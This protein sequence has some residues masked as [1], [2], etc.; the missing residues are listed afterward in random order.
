M[1]TENIFNKNG[2]ELKTITS[3]AGTE[4]GIDRERFIKLAGE[5]DY[6]Y[7]VAWLDNIVLIGTCH[8]GN[9]HFYDPD[10]HFKVME[11]DTGLKY[12]QK[13]RVFNDKKELFVWRR[14]N[15]WD[16]RI[17]EDDTGN[18]NFDVVVAQQLLFGTKDTTTPAQKNKG[19]SQISED[20]GTMLVLPFPHIKVN[21]EQD[22]IFI[23]THNY[24]KPKPVNEIQDDDHFI[25]HQAGYFDCR[26]VV[27][28]DGKNELP[29]R[30]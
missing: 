1:G 17:R 13:I 8:N 24:I 18:E 16:G 30:I 12:I 28:T 4:T 7:V 22:R 15:T 20:R 11:K 2:L 27:F 29:G 23:K 25:I 10:K 26:F 21:E 6:A 14:Q 3:K 5:F 19:Y 9:F